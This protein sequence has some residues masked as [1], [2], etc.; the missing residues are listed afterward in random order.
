MKRLPGISFPL[1]CFTGAL[2]GTANMQPPAAPSRAVTTLIESDKISRAVQGQDK[3]RERISYLVRLTRV[4]PE[5][6]PDLTLQWCDELFTLASESPLGWDHVA[7]QKNAAIPLAKIDPK[8]ALELLARVDRPQPHAT[9]SNFTEDVRADAAAVIFPA[10]VQTYGLEGLPQIQRQANLIGETGEYPY[11]AMAHVIDWI[12][13]SN[14][15]TSGQLAESIFRD[16]LGNYKR[17]SK[18]ED[19]EDEFFDILSSS[20]QVI[21]PDLFREALELYIKRLSVPAKGDGVFTANVSTSQGAI[22][23]LDDQ[24]KQLMWRVF[25]LLAEFDHDW[26][27]RLIEQN[28]QLKGAENGVTPLG[29]AFIPGHPSKE[30]ADRKHKQ[31]LE[32]ALLPKVMLLTESDHA[33]AVKLAISLTPPAR[34]TAVSYVLP[35]LVHSNPTGAKQMYSQQL[36]DMQSVTAPVEQLQAKVAVAK[37]AYYLGDTVRLK[38]LTNKIMDDAILLFEKDSKRNRADLHNGYREMVDIV[39]FAAAHDLTWVLQR[40]AHIENPLLRAHTMIFMA[41]GFVESAHTSQVASGA[42]QH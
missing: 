37:S 19:E 13:T 42:P 36:A 16:A 7:N 6:T 18:F 1:L 35:G 34:I 9:G 22:I 17:E 29:A 20:R 28:P 31:M 25:S 4:S 26:S 8:R 23:Q 10:F 15:L 30:Y 12:A 38:R 32:A 24:N 40:V 39:E 2:L 14:T 11:R 21:S 5:I 3:N 33:A 41:K 27:Q